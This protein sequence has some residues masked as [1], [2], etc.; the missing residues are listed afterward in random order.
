MSAFAAFV[1][2]SGSSSKGACA[3][4][5]DN[6]CTSLEACDVQVA[7]CR[8]SCES[9]LTDK[10]C[11]GQSPP[12]RLTCAEL[13]EAVECAEYCT[14]LCERAPSCGSFDAR[15]CVTGCLEIEPSIC[16]PASVAARTCDQLKPELRFYESVGAP[17]DGEHSAGG[18]FGAAYGLCTDADD[19]DEP[20]GC[21]QETNVCTRCES[22]QD[23][24]GRIGAYLCSDDKECVKVDCLADEDCALGRPCD[25]KTHECG[26]CREDAD[27]SFLRSACDT[28]TMKCVECN[29]DADC[30]EP[31]PSCDVAQQKCVECGRD[32]DCEYS[33][34][35]ACDTARRVC[36]EC[37]ED[38]HCT[39]NYAPACDVSTQTCVE[40]KEDAHCPAESPR[41]DA[42]SQT[43]RDCASN[44][45]CSTSRP[46]CD[47]TLF[48]TAC[49]T[50]ADCEDHEKPYCSELGGC[51]DCGSDL[52]CEEGEQ[53]DTF[54][55][56][57][58]PID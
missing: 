16:N 35:P 53:C 13:T 52:D 55:G 34:A 24:A 20:L 25:T 41:C 10:A 30:S 40:C 28:A 43:C 17:S 15:A 2:C 7:D 32:S 38:A 51:G 18:G 21:S 12:D 5:C 4:Y 36:V 50:D 3:A 33:S 31:R 14:T 49:E 46:R 47:A 22:N 39:D 42:E 45:D 56:V 1:G 23:C 29:A 57:C 19:C 27:C 6:L 8:S 37:K 58:L 11:Q 54:D 44:A 9:E 26:E 48:C